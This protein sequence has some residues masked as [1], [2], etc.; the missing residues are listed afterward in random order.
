MTFYHY[1]NEHV[2]L[3]I[4]YPGQLW[5]FASFF[6]I[7]IL[8]GI[9]YLLSTENRR[10]DAEPVDTVYADVYIEWLKEDGVM[11][12]VHVDK[13]YR[14]FTMYVLCFSKRSYRSFWI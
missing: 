10:R 13:V 8:L 6:R 3:V 9:Q 14:L 4:A 2:E 11:E 5:N 1:P 12:K 7:L